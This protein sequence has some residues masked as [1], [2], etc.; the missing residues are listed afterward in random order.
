MRVMHVTLDSATNN[1][2]Q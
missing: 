1:T 2:K